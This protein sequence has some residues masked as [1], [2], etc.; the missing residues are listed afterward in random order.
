M[1]KGHY[2][3]GTLAANDTLVRDVSVQKSA[4]GNFV[5]DKVGQRQRKYTPLIKGSATCD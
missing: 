1:A 4:T 5:T 3:S 2:Y